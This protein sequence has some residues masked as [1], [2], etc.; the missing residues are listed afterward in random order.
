RIPL[1]EISQIE[2]KGAFGSGALKVRTAN[3]GATVAFFS[4]SLLPKFSKVSKQI[5]SLVKEARPVGDDEE[6]VKRNLDGA[7]GKKR[8]CEKCGNVI[9]RWSGVCPT[10]LD[11]RRLF[12]RLMSYSLPYWSL[13]TT[14]LA[15][16]LTATFIGL[17]PPLLM[18]TLIDDVLA[19]AV[20]GADSGPTTLAP[21]RADVRSPAG[22][23]RS[24]PIAQSA[25]AISRRG[26][27]AI[28]VALLLLVNLSR[29][30]LGALRT[31][32]L[33]KLGQRITFDLRRQVYR[34]IHHL[35][36][37][38]YNERETGRIMAS[39]TQDVGRL[40]DFISDGLQEIIRDI[41]TILIICI[42]LFS[43]NP[44]LAAVVLLPT[45]LLVL[46]TRIFG[47]WFHDVY[48][49]L[50]RRWAGMSALLADTI[51]G[52]RVV[53]AFAQEKREVNKFERSSWDL[54][55]G[56]V[57]AARVRSAF[58]PIM[59]FI[60]SL[61]TLIVWWMGGSQVLGG[62]LTLGD[63]VAF[64][65]YM[66]M[67]F[68][69]VE[70]LCFLNH[71]FQRAA[72][73]A[74]RV[75]EVLDTQADVVD[76]PDAV[77]MPRIVGR[78][79]FRNVTFGYEPGKPVL[80][81]LNFVVEPGEMI[82][83]AGHSG[84]GKS[85]LINLICR[86]YDGE[87]GEILIDGYDI[88]DVGLKPLRE[89]IGVVLQ[90]PFLFNGT[91]AENIA[92]GKPEAPLDEV[93]AAAK[94]ANAHDFVIG[95]QEGYDSIV[96]ER[97]MRVSGGERQRLSIARAILRDPR[98]LILDEATASVDTETEAMIQEALERLVKG[99]TTFAIAHRL[100]TLKNSDRLL[101]LEKGELA[102]M[103]TH[104]E[105]IVQDGIYANLC[106]MQTEMSK[107]RAW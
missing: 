27:L 29:N 85:T 26:L 21:S 3:T 54:L 34:H 106:R 50:W 66:F 62:T 98:V 61:G 74:E 4:K 45:P 53:K 95:F 20:I 41:A 78:V 57:R 47:K 42:I 48:H 68:H 56:E 14:S 44:G 63:F 59:T 24:L 80:K 104:D 49:S 33:A 83:L 101:I 102:E 73:S 15:L 100:S 18:R 71:R 75:F 60:T 58:G 8:R 2:V 92:Y 90:D 81:D 55:A 91:I 43:L 103:G 67:F 79:E 25:G 13:A 35:S 99:R 107:L 7:H 46:T 77:R 5:E 36:L 76:K 16:L 69:P 51:P 84:A 30:G 82:G 19:P 9:P 97:G 17:T 52:V 105:L 12:V 87:E 11:R 37:T 40:Q 23:A 38:F 22:R 31:Y 10:C 32:L 89:Q 65:G 64:T 88:R 72:T 1:S 39:V 93:V 96:G 6:I 86:F 28:L 70:H 94:A